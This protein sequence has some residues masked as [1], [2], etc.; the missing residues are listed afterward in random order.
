MIIPSLQLFRVSTVTVTAP[1]RVVTVTA[2]C[3]DR[4]RTVQWP[5]R[6][7]V[8]VSER[9]LRACA[10]PLSVSLF[11]L[12]IILYGS[13]IWTQVFVNIHAIYNDIFATFFFLFLVNHDSCNNFLWISCRGVGF[14][15][16][17]VS[18]ALLLTMLIQQSLRNPLAPIESF[19]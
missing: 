9:V 1:H 14:L 10:C 5:C 6:D 12:F 16:T 19:F 17:F 4:D 8:R 11:F 15:S 18:V 2:P 13:F 3:S 7:R